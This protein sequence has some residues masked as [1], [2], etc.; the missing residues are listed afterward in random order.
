MARKDRTMSKERKVI[1]ILDTICT[2]LMA[3]C[4]IVNAFKGDFRAAI[5]WNMN[6]TIWL[7]NTLLNV[8]FWQIEKLTKKLT[9]DE[10]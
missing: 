1:L 6:F 7:C 8:V 3:V 4:V 2:I 9:E 5:L 10:K